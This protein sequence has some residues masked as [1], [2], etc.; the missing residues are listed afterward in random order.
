MKKEYLLIISDEAYFDIS[1]AYFWYESAKKGLGDQFESSLEN[2]LK[3]LMISPQQYQERH[4]N[5]R[6]VFLLRF[7]F[8]IHYVIEREFI[9]VIAV[10]HTSRNPKSWSERF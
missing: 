3:Q 4:K 8:G 6:I 5:V 9:K 1:E 10:F 7:P 2:S